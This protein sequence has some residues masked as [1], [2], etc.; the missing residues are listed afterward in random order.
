MAG[1]PKMEAK[2]DSGAA[3]TKAGQEVKADVSKEA[4]PDKASGETTGVKSPALTV[5]SCCASVSQL[6]YQR[7]FAC[8]GTVMQ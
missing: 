5:R 3:G 1:A 4:A 7:S 2:T 6:P 8:Y